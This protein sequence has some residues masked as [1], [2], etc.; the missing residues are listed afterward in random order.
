M[1]DD[2]IALHL[3]EAQP[4]FSSSPFHRLPSQD[5]DWTTPSGMDFVVH[6]M[7]QTLVVGRVQ[8]NLSLSRAAHKQVCRCSMSA[9]VAAHAAN[10]SN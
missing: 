9:S 7:L 1:T 3:S 2:A 10:S 4:S 6:H 5:L 8:E